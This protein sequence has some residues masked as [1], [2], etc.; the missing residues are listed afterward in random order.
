M[1]LEKNETDKGVPI[2]FVRLIR[3]GSSTFYDMLVKYAKKRGMKVYNYRC[4]HQ[5]LDGVFRR[6]YGVYA[7]HQAYNPEMQDNIVPGGKYVVLLREPVDRVLSEYY[8]Y[9]YDAPMKA[10]EMTGFQKKLVGERKMSFDEWFSKEDDNYMHSGSVLCRQDNHMTKWLSYPYK[11]DLEQAKRNLEKFTV[12]GLME[13]YDLFLKKVKDR[14]GFTEQEISYVQKKR[15]N[16]NRPRT[17]TGGLSEKQMELIKER[18]KLDGELYKYA[19]EN[20]C[21]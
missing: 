17:K 10:K 5:E 1:D 18:N 21:L 7:F 4:Y 11:C 13:F 12:V 16:A 19:K 20:Y 3:V 8:K 2:I 15:Y 6:P 9:L 14:L